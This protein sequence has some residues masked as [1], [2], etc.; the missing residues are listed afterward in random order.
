MA[1]SKN[2]EGANEIG[3]KSQEFE[4]RTRAPLTPLL[5][6]LFCVRGGGVDARV[7]GIRQNFPGRSTSSR[8]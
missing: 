3:T 5:H 2:V 7:M 6:F 1:V 4:T 8:L